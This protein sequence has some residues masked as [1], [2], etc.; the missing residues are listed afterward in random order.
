EPQHHHCLLRHATSMASFAPFQSRKLRRR[1]MRR[2]HNVPVSLTNWRTFVVVCRLSSLSA[3]ANE[4][5][6]TQSAISRQL[7]AL[8]HEAGAPL[9]RRHPRGVATTAAGEAFRGHALAV[10]NEADRAVRAA[11]DVR[12]GRPT[13]PLVVGATP[14]LAAGVVP[15]AMRRF[16]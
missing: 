15:A 1:G 14:S 2:T 6:Y 7:A 8:E 12:D 16:R 5:G 11:L 10:I 3:A 4:L 9:L 13:R